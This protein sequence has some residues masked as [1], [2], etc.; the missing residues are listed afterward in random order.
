MSYAHQIFWYY[1]HLSLFV[2]GWLSARTR[3][4]CCLAS[5]WWPT[6]SGPAWTSGSSPS[7]TRS[8]SG[9]PKKS[10]TFVWLVNWQLYT[11]LFLPKIWT[12]FQDPE[13]PHSSTL[14]ICKPPRAPPPPSFAWLLVVWA[15]TFL[16]CSNYVYGY[17]LVNKMAFY[18]RFT[19]H[20]F[21]SLD[22][23]LTSSRLLFTSRGNHLINKP[24]SVSHNNCFMVTSVS[25]S[26]RLYI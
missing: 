4:T 24:W 26:F 7:R 18:L 1:G 2:P 13:D 17:W 20:I 8:S 22:A 9:P 5:W 12:K 21:Q 15:Q 19:L 14:K 23:L 10:R 6:S 11:P 25:Q 3:A 16:Q